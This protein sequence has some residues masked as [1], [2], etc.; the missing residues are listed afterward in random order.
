V[1]NQKMAKE[2]FSKTLR[3]IFTAAAVAAKFM[4]DGSPILM[5]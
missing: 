3:D 1:E 5:D 2:N 4:L